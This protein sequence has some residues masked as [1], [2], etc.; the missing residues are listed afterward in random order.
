MVK[1]YFNGKDTFII[2]EKIQIK[3]YTCTYN[4]T[5]TTNCHST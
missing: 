3:T 4:F 1:T 2:N 5:F